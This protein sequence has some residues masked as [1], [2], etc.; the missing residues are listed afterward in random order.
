MGYIAREFHEK[1][2]FIK[3][4]K[5]NYYLSPLLI[6]NKFT[7]AFFTKKSSDFEPYWLSE[8]FNQNHKNCY[9]KQIHSSNI[10][11]GSNTYNNKEINADGLICDDF[12]QNLWIYSA[13]CMPI[14]FADKKNK[15]VAAIHCGRKGLQ[16]KIIIKLIKSLENLGSKKKDLLVAIGPSI[17]KSNYLLDKDSFE[18]FNRNLNPK[19][20]LFI[21]NYLRKY[22]FKFDNPK[23][24]KLIA[25][26]IRK[27]AYR[28]LIN[29]NI[30]PQ[31]IEISNKCTHDNYNE[32][33]SYRRSQTVLRQWSFIAS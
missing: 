3:K 32:F 10:I 16:K 22:N 27:I 17:S 14:L 21:L 2:V 25:L 13:D 4:L 24:K 8:G 28:Q 31:N 12:D 26:D 15:K 29:E 7:H 18:K 1:E 20:H 6:N 19:N 5:I 9:L 30:I 33:H 23:D 11:H